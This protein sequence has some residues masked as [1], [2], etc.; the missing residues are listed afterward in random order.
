MARVPLYARNKLASSVVGTPGVGQ[1]DTSAAQVLS[2]IAANIGGL[3]DT[4]NQ[5]HIAQVAENQ[6]Q[7]RIAQERQRQEQ[8]RL[9]GLRRRV[10]VDYMKAQAQT[11]SANIL[12]DLQQKHMWDVNGVDTAYQKSMGEYLDTTLEGVQDEETRLMLHQDFSAVMAGG[13]TAISNFK[14]SRFEP[15]A[16]EQLK[17]TASEFSKRVN[18]ATV[19]EMEAAQA[20]E[21][22]KADT[23]ESYRVV[24]GPGAEAAQRDDIG[25]G[26]KNYVTAIAITGNTERLESV[27]E[28]KLTDTY[29]DK[30]ELTP[31]AAEKRRQVREVAQF[32]RVQA[33]RERVSA[34]AE[35]VDQLAARAPDGDITKL[36]PQDI[37]KFITDNPG[38]SNS[39]KGT[40]VR[41]K[42]KAEATVRNSKNDAERARAL[43]TVHKD[44]ERTQRQVIALEKRIREGDRSE[45]T[46]NAYQTSA[47]SLIEYN[48]V[49]TA[50]VESL[51]DSPSY[52]ALGAAN[53]AL[54][55]DTKTNLTKFTKDPKRREENLRYNSF[56]SKAKEY[57][58]R[59]NPSFPNPADNAFVQN[60]YQTHFRTR[61]AQIYEAAQER[62]QVDTLL[63]N[64]V[65]LKSLYGSAHSYALQQAKEALRRRNQKR[66]GQ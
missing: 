16:R 42:G 4:A 25:A 26:I 50:L 28:S 37:Q 10:E 63:K 8:A 5:I 41:A 14:Q 44:I 59:Y 61:M 20:A 24:H 21:Q 34:D 45:K 1:V 51:K 23:L 29:L 6:R 17:G 7:I 3:A 53:S 2:G 31:F 13:A 46:L 56:M 58:A 11:H 52:A 55:K 60:I 39:L 22:Y 54:L 49:A 19:T 32:Q 57:A 35:F 27:L 33:Y 9:D 43:G 38:M 36:A 62:N 15:I 18:K 65:G 30:S 48:S 40:L 47:Q 66:N 12:N 64:A